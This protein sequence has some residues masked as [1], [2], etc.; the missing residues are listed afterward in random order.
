VGCK[1]LILLDT[2]C[3]LWLDQAVERMSRRARR[4]VDAASRAGDLGVSAISFW[5]VAMLVAKQRLRISQP[6]ASWRREWLQ[7]GVVE[8][9]MTGAIGIDAALLATFHT[10]PADRWIV[11][12]AREID[13]VL[14]T[15]DDRILAWPGRLD[16]QDAR[17]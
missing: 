17:V 1:P 16:R 12:T 3:L 14:L 7:Q 10:D 4:L 8:L 15:A 13:A 6:L 5:E 11:A 9:P 2:H